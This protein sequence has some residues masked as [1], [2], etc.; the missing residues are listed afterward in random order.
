MSPTG[1]FILIGSGPGIGRSTASLFA[2]K[3]FNHFVLLSRN[4]SRLNEDA[5]AV[6]KAS[7]DVKVETF[8]LDLAGDEQSIKSVL[9]K[10]DEVLKGWNVQLECVL[11]NGARVGPSKI[12]E[13]DVK[14]L[15]EDLRVSQLTD[16]S[17][18]LN[19]HV[20]VR[21]WIG[22]VVLSQHYTKRLPFVHY[23]PA[24]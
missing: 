6:R 4:A 1:A 5:D 2:E 16:Y 9:G 22:F 24:D 8:E 12:M 11:Y 17:T 23:M 15:E 10:V 18:L 14:G 7:S 20:H 19:E 3:G 21:D 13:W